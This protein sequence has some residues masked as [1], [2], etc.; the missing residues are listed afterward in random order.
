[1]TAEPTNFYEYLQSLPANGEIHAAQDRYGRAIDALDGV[2]AMLIELKSAAT[3]LRS[4]LQEGAGSDMPA[5]AAYAS[6][7][8]ADAQLA[9]AM[10]NS[11]LIK[12][13][14]G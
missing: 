14:Q 12:G 3:A 10:A 13:A 1:M 8:S 2:E 7:L 4:L 6:M 9:G 5:V 11:P